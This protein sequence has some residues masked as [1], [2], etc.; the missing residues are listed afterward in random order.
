MYSIYC[1][2]RDAKGCSDSDVAK[3]TGITKSTFTDWKKVRSVP[4]IDKL[5]KIAEYFGV[6]LDYLILGIDIPRDYDITLDNDVKIQ[7]ENVIAILDNEES[8]LFDG[9]QINLTNEDRQI[10]KNALDF[11]YNI[12]KQHA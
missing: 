4:K 9:K 11:A 5:I 8:I 6:S 7:L 1:K 2:L 10:I 12:L 3:A